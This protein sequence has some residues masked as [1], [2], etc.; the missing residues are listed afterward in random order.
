MSSVPLKKAIDQNDDQ[1]PYG[2]VD[3]ADIKAIGTFRR[4]LPQVMWWTIKIDFLYQM[5]CNQNHFI[6]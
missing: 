2:K 4:I 1:I 3:D 5:D 6:F